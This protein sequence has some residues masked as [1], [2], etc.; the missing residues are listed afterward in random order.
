[1]DATHGLIRGFNPFVP[2]AA[3]LLLGPTQADE[4]VAPQLNRHSHDSA[5]EPGITLRETTTAFPHT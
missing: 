4:R 5:Q 3:N 2:F 1:M